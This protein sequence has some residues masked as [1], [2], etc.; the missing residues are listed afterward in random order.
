MLLISESFTTNLSSF[1]LKIRKKIT[2]NR[3]NGEAIDINKSDK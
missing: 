1:L 3:V 2:Q